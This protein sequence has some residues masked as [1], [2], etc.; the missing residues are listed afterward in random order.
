[1]SESLSEIM[2]QIGPQ[3]LSNLDFDGKNLNGETTTSSCRYLFK[4]D[5]ALRLQNTFE[6]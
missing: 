3:D 1:M 6:C 4:I 2:K 5:S